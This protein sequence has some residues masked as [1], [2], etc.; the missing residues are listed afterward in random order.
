MPI[1]CIGGIDTA[2]AQ[3]VIEAGAICIAVV[4]AVCASSDPESSA[5]NLKRILLE[6]TKQEGETS[7]AEG[8]AIG[9]ET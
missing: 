4:R 9:G 7:P 3:E 1:V 8:G 6:S 2:T 5:R